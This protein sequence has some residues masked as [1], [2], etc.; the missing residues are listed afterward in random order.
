LGNKIYVLAGGHVD[1]KKIW[2]YDPVSNVWD[3][4]I[5]LMNAAR[6][7]PELQVVCGRI[8]AIGGS[9]SSSVDVLSSVE[10]WE[11]GESSW[12]IEPPLNIARFQFASAVIG[13]KIYVFGGYNGSSL[14]STEVLTISEPPIL[15]LVLLCLAIL[16]FFLVI[17][18][19]F[20]RKALISYFL[21]VFEPRNQ[22]L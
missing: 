12:R 21:D 11:P 10:S 15:S 7:C 1:L 17:I 8:Y 9:N 14:A 20:N 6:S 16:C 5:P 18:F 3:T 13:N 19:W 22:A 4:S 2:S